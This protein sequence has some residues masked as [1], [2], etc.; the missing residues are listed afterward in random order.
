VRTETSPI[1]SFYLWSVPPP[2]PG[3]TQTPSW[4]IELAT[5]CAGK[6]VTDDGRFD[7]T[8]D[9]AT[10]IAELRREIAALSAD[11]PYAEWGRWFLSDRSTRS[12]APGFM[13]SLADANALATESASSR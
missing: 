7:D 5:V 11:A 9:S 12:I 3:G 2:L 8:P 1:G 10:K 6:R 13:L 4:L